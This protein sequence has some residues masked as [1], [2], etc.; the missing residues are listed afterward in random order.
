MRKTKVEIPQTN[1]NYIS[2]TSSVVFTNKKVNIDI[3]DEMIKDLKSALIIY[4]D[5][6]YI[7]EKRNEKIDKL[8]NEGAK[9]NTK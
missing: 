6:Y 7:R 5:E 1:K 8:L 2:A 9:K 4:D 3:D